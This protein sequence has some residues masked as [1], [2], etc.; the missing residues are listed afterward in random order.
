MLGPRWRVAAT[1]DLVI[2]AR[3]AAIDTV[4]ATR[5]RGPYAIV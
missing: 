3:L 2:A 4:A 1:T 5:K